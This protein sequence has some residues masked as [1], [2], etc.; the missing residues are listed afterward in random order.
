MNKMQFFFWISLL[1]LGCHPG[2]GPHS[3]P[4]LQEIMETDRAFSSLSRD[5]GLRIAFLRYLDGG[6][7]LLRPSHFPI[8]GPEAVKYLQASQDSTITLTWVPTGGDLASSGD[9]G[10]TYGVY[11]LRDHNSDSSF[12][13]TY[14]TIWKKQSDGGWK[15]VLDSGN[16]GLGH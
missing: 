3:A 16:P 5:S 6:G 11:S 4:P 14:V 12:G 8:L 2:K 1:S 13:G 10:Y 15:Y 9:L 7:V